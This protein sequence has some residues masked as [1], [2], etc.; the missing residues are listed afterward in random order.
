MLSQKI[1]EAN[2]NVWL[3]NTGWTGGPYGVGKR[4]SL[5]Y[6]RALITAALENKLEK[7]EYQTHDVFGL[8]MPL[9]CPGVPENILNPRNTWT[10]KD[11]YDHQANELA[12]AFLKNFEKFADY[13]NEDIMAGAPRVNQLSN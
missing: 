9:T 4:M 1:H 12:T 2:V 10:D 6:T 7:V 8:S 13:A 5:P 11:A 3:V